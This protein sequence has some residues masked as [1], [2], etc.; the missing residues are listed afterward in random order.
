MEKKVHNNKRYG[1]VGKDI[2]YSFSRSYFA[3]KFQKEGIDN[4]IYENFDL[5]SIDVI[6]TVLKMQNLG[7]L[8]VTTPYKEEILPYINHL[9]EDAK[10]IGAVN[11]VRILADGTTEGHNTDSY[12]FK[13][14][15]LRQWNGHAKKALILGT[16]GASKAVHYVLQQ[17]NIEPLFVSRNPKEGQI[18]YEQIDSVLMQSHK[19]IINCTPI[20][21]HPNI[22]QAPQI[23]Y[24]L[25]DSGHFLFDLIY[26]PEVTLFLAKGKK[27]GATIQNGHFMLER[28]AEK[29][30]NI[31]NE[32]PV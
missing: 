25:I 1:L 10:I 3:K 11:T 31:W 30:W 15:L 27:K 23:P 18:T 7:G 4:C 17:M 22:D 13:A 19:L 21:T 24:N 14:A 6:K 28:Q 29:S 9:T 5:E 8:N 2:N 32:F 26:N 12:G 16:G 20:G